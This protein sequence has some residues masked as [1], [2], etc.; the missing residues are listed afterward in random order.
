MKKLD[1][2]VAVITGGA[3]GIGEATVKLFIDEGARVVFGDIEDERG[4][5]LAAEL[6]DGALFQHTDVSSE[7]DIKALIGLAVDKFGQLD[8]MFNNAGYGGPNFP[9]D[10]TP[11][12][13]YDK[14]MQVLLR[15]VVIGTKYA[16]QQMKKRKS[17]SIISTSS[18]SG[19]QAGFAP[20]TYSM[21]KAG[22]IQMTKTTSTEVGEFGIR[23]NCI[24]P[25]GI[26]TGIFGKGLGLP[27]E[28]AEK[29]IEIMKPGL[30]AAQPIKKAGL[31][32]DIAKAALWLAS[33][34]SSFVSG[35]ALVVDG[36]LTAG[37]N[38]AEVTAKLA[39]GFGQNPAA[40]PEKL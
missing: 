31:P 7:D 3:Y 39:S 32:E 17:G 19:L 12:D 21:A 13:E 2:K 11:I 29:V 4:K 5:K 20:H 15:A 38:F 28:A 16:V 10:E 22:I 33:D 40:R 24:C 30:A 37:R 1:G 23:V 25:G 35:H 8:I 14:A 36:A 6:G 27:R 18:V 26:A 34:D 9:I